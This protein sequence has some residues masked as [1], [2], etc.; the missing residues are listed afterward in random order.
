[1]IDTLSAV[2]SGGSGWLLPGWP[3][4]DVLAL[5]G[6]VVAAVGVIIAMVP[7]SR[8]FVQRLWRA[9][10]MRAGFPHHRYARWFTG[11]WGTYENPYL[12][13]EERLDLLS[14]YVPLSFQ[15][16]DAPQNVAIATAVLTRLPADRL[17]IVGDPGSGKSTLLKA[18]GVG[19]LRSRHILVR[20]QRVVPYL[21]QLR[22]LARFI[23][24]DKGIAEYITGEILVREGV[25]R[26]DRAREFF[27]YTLERR[28]AVV[29]LDGLDEVPD[30]RQ[31]AVLSAVRDFV[32]DKTQDR[33]TA[34]ARILLTCR[35]Q[36]FESLRANWIPAVAK[37]DSLYALAPLRDSEIIGYLRRFEHKFRSAEG[38]ARFMKSVRDSKT[39]DLLR[40]PLVLAMS[41]GLYARRPSM[42]PSTVAELYRSMIEEMLERHSFRHDDPEESVLSYR[43]TDKYGFL[44]QFALSAVRK[45]GE[46]GEFTRADLVGLSADLASSFDAVDDPKGLVDEII[47]HSGLLSDVGDEGVYVFAH[48]SIQE[49][50]AA[51]ELQ[52][53]RDGDELLLDRAD[54][55]NWRQTVQFYTA[56]R[57]ARLVDAFVRKLAEGNSELA[58]HCLQAAKPSDEA[59]ADVLHALRPITTGAQVSA[60]AAATRSPRVSVQKMAIEQLKD[61]IT[62]SGA[63][64][65]AT[66]EGVDGMLPLLDSLAGTNAAE[67]AG[68]VPAVI[69]QM[70][71]DPRLVGPLWQ[72]LNA[73]GIELRKKE[74]SAIVARLLT[75]VMDPDSFAE[76]ERQDPQDRDFL[77][78]IRPAAYPFK[79]SFPP[80]HNLVTLLAWAEHLGV[81]VPRPNRFLQAKSAGRLDR[82][83]SDRRRTLSFVPFQPARIVSSVMLIAALAVAFAVLTVEP[84]KQILHPDGW[85]MLWI[86]FLVGESGIWIHL[87]GFTMLEAFWKD[88]EPLDADDVENCGNIA[89]SK[90][91]VSGMLLVAPFAFAVAPVPLL[92]D[93]LA[94]YILVSVGCQA[95]FWATGVKMFTR[96]RRYYPYRPNPFVDI[97]DDPR[98]R[99]WLGLAGP[100]L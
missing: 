4:S 82:V 55:L 73:S 23:T 33:P 99:H 15:S 37:R 59:A 94:V 47:K 84:E 46:F 90:F 43:V 95:L 58:A 85:W 40:A 86:F 51:V 75:L 17:V 61:V 70:P 80:D 77:A 9:M 44:R 96:G 88:L 31:R 38:P 98:S 93:S 22:K 72:C 81:S 97:Y 49:F 14:T 66:S 7:P 54:D 42:I 65:F 48:R 6:V 87:I 27:G 16:D 78:D 50:L 60:L 56:G 36:N 25:M 41:V 79:N 39:L 26:P 5:A 68:L 21:V 100:G 67:I 45:T 24:A 57:E 83:E 69:A 3:R 52:Q 12:G 29:M 63:L 91:F 1:M 11:A 53:L 89:A 2:A 74:C 28:Q 62:A 10:L 19:I 20:R 13:E 71:D 64:F 35:T 92:A 76:L 18:Y 8:H 32:T 34:Q 30:D